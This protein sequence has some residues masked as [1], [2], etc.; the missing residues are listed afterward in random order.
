M[1]QQEPAKAGN[2]EL[3]WKAPLPNMTLRMDDHRANSD[4]GHYTDFF[5]HLLPSHLF[6]AYHN[7]RSRPTFPY[8]QG[9]L[10][11]TGILITSAL[12]PHP[13]T[14]LTSVILTSLLLS[15]SSTSTPG[16]ANVQV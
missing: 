2:V 5:P 12:F 7:P 1:L 14:P 15:V 16:F 6:G 3:E 4:Y 9:N 8:R 13:L 11:L 10:S